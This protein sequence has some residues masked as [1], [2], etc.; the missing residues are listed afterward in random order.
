MEEAG[1][2]AGG[3]GTQ[4]AARLGGGPGP[5][6]GPDGEAPPAPGELTRWRQRALSAEARLEEAFSKLGEVEKA[7]DEARLALDRTELKHRIER[8]LAEAEAIDLETAS[9]LTE[10]AVS[11]METP[12]VS[13]AVGELRRRK[14]W[15]FRPGWEREGSMSATASGDG[16]ASE[17]LAEEAARTGDRRTLLR[18][19]RSRR[20]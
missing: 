15:L 17:A 2:E 20:G 9:M 8:E 18:Y 5:G 19:L 13:A 11:R 12:D 10:A 7:L 3:G 16:G 6:P 1:G 4:G 14:P